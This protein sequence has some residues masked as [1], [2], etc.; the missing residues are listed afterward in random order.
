MLQRTEPSEDPP[1]AH[2]PKE[3]VAVR[4][5]VVVRGVNQEGHPLWAPCQFFQYVFTCLGTYSLSL[6]R[7]FLPFRFDTFVPS[8]IRDRLLPISPCQKPWPQHSSTTLRA[9]VRKKV[10]RK[11]VRRNIV[12]DT[13]QAEDRQGFEHTIPNEQRSLVS[14]EGCSVRT[15]TAGKGCGGG[16]LVD[17]LPPWVLPST[18]HSSSRRLFLLLHRGITEKSD[19]QKTS[20][21]SRP[22]PAWPQSGGANIFGQTAAPRGSA[23]KTYS[24]A[25][26][27]PAPWENAVGPGTRSWIEIRQ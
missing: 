26:S 10:R 21:F 18:T 22:L 27:T 17:C 13:H 24:I 25:V 2:V 6:A 7:R 8:H 16:V 14:S 19:T 23:R 20:C 11:K 9:H 1:S 5:V 15:R 12:E 4:D 3:D